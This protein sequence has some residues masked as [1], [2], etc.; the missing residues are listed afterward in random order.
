LKEQNKELKTEIDKLRNNEYELIELQNE[1]KILKN[2]KRLNKEKISKLQGKV[3]ALE[4]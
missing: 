4:E 3:K 2:E 1:Y